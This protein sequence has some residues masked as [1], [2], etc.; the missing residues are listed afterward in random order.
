MHKSVSAL[1]MFRLCERRG[2]LLKYGATP[3]GLTRML[4]FTITRL[5]IRRDGWNVR[6]HKISF[7]C[8]V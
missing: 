7:S 3:A 5:I 4:T 2:A 8:H 1:D 6:P